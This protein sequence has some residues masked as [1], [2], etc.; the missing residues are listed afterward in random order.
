MTQ[1]L[2]SVAFS[3]TSNKIDGLTKVV[4]FCPWV[5]SKN[6][7]PTF[8]LVIM[9]RIRSLNGLFILKPITKTGAQYFRPDSKVI[10][11][12][13]MLDLISVETIKDLIKRISTAKA[14]KT[15]QG[16]KVNFIGQ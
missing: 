11:E 5:K 4:V 1:L 3:V 14:P 12:Q 7:K 6:V 2:Y 9:S 8:L 10:R 16:G 13:E 15:N